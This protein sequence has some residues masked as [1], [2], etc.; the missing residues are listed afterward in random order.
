MSERGRIVVPKTQKQI[1]KGMHTPYS[2]ESGNPNDAAHQATDRSNQVS[3]K[4]DTVKPFTVG[5]YDIDETI[6][7]Y[8]NNVIKPTVVQNGKRTE[9]P[10]IYANS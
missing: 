3:F 10:V 4:G 1:S 5:L 8:F 7:Y 2:K 6:L 9:V